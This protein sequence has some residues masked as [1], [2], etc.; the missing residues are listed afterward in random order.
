MRAE[1][2]GRSDIKSDTRQPPKAFTSRQ[3]RDYRVPLEGPIPS[4]G[5][6]V[7][8]VI[9]RLRYVRA[10]FERWRGRSL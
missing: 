6:Q 4:G 1:T 8:S 2:S 3:G 10:V 7:G 5:L 9:M